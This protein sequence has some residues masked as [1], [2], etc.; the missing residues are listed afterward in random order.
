MSRNFRLTFWID[1]IFG[2][3]VLEISQPV[4]VCNCTVPIQVNQLKLL[5]FLFPIGFS[6]VKPEESLKDVLSAE[7]KKKKLQQVETV[8]RSESAVSAAATP[9]KILKSESTFAKS[10]GQRG[11]GCVSLLVYCAKTDR[12]NFY[13]LLTARTK[14]RKLFLLMSGVKILQM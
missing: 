2:R 10:F 13:S 7:D 9:M 11:Y 6:S 1:R 3:Q 5:F 14:K 4:L 8:A 12:L